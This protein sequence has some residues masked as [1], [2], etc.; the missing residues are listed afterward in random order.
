MTHSA[1]PLSGDARSRHRHRSIER[2][3]S[4]LEM[5]QAWRARRRDRRI[6]ADMAEVDHYLLDDIGVTRTDLLREAS[7]PFWRA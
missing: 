5:I 3:T 2:L 1:I 4:V 7:K 6:L